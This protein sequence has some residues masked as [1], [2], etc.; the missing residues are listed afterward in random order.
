[1]SSKLV[2]IDGHAIMHRAFH[3]MPPLSTPS[4]E[5]INAV[6]GTISMLLTII[7]NLKPTHLTFVFDEKAPTFRNKLSKE[8]QAQRPEMASE[9]SSQFDKIKKFLEVAKIPYYSKAG[10]E[11]DDVIGTIANK[12]EHTVIVTGD[13]DILQV[14]DDERDIKLFMPIA[15]LSNGK[16]F[17]EKETYERMG[18]PPSQ[19]S[20]LK[21]L[22][23]DPSDNYFGV[24]GIGPVT[25]IKLLEEYKSIDN[26]YA[27]LDKINPK[28][29]EKLDKGKESAELS[30]KLSTMDCEVPIEFNLPQ[31]GKWKLSSPEVVKLFTNEFGFKTLTAR[32]EKLGKSIEEEKQGSLF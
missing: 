21:A 3:A 22:V 30:L 1:M 5:P 18:V 4:G 7:Q 11:A 17:G 14:V 2:I 12:I 25:A 16:L 15:G 19:I 9:L 13:R 26:I 23:G 6:H 27:Q 8:Y 20:N 31:M 10:Y 29:R 28:I 32:I 24:A